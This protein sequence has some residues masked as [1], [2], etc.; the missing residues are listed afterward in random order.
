MR[1]DFRH[2]RLDRMRAPELAAE[3]AAEPDKT[4]EVFLSRV[5]A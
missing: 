5:R 4:L 2:F 3:F 1:V